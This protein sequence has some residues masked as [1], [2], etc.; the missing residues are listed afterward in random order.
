MKLKTISDILN[1]YWNFI[2][3]LMRIINFGILVIV[4][5][6]RTLLFNLIADS[7]NVFLLILNFK[8]D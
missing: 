7:S 8:N 1:D 2:C 4:L 5:F 6:N 3:N